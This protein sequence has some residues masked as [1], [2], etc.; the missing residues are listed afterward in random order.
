MKV[1]KIALVG[2]PGSGKSKLIKKLFDYY[3]RDYHVIICNNP[4]TKLIELGY[5]PPYGC[6]T[7]E[8]QCLLLNRYLTDYFEVERCIGEIETSKQIHKD[9]LVIYNTLPEDGQC[10]YSKKCKE[11]NWEEAYNLYNPAMHVDYTFLLEL[12]DTKSQSIDL[13]FDPDK[14]LLIEENLS[15]IHRNA[16]KLSKSLDLDE[17]VSYIDGCIHPYIDRCTQV[18]CNNITV[19]SMRVLQMCSECNWSEYRDLNQLANYCP[20]CGS[21]H[22]H[23]GQTMTHNKDV[24]GEEAR[25]K[26]FYVDPDNLPYY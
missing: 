5:R 4:A 25:R 24:L 8:F 26:M 12:R 13:N 9:I 15:N 3:K 23:S 11:N 14:L 21:S 6:T 2:A 19:S 20:R 16:I 22:V 17:M 10:Y 7:D 18:K 1:T